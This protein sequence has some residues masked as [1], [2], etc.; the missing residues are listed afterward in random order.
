MARASEWIEASEAC[1]HRLGEKREKGAC[2]SVYECL[3]VCVCVYVC[4][5][6]LA[7]LKYYYLIEDRVRVEEFLK[8]FQELLS[9]I[10]F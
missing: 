3:R 6:E 1:S 2:V 9:V 7:F 5:L 8:D 10:F 4:V